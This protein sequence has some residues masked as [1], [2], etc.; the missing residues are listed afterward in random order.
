MQPHKKKAPVVSGPKVR[1][2]IGT[3]LSDTVEFHRLWLKEC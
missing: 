1:E 2:Q 3:R